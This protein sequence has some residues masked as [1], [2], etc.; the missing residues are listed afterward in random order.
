MRP[1][2]PGC[3]VLG[4]SGVVAGRAEGSHGLGN[5]MGKGEK[6]LHPFIMYFLNDF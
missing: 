2:Q 5:R 4:T 1:Y 6:K 3:V